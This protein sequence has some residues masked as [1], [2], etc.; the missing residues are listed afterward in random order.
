[1]TT[2][3][4]QK[5]RELAY[6]AETYRLS[7]NYENA[8]DYF[9]EA[10]KY[11]PNY[12]WA[13]AHRGETYRLIP[14]YDNAVRDFSKAIERAPSAWNFAHR[15]ATYRVMGTDYQTQAL[16]DLNQ[17]INLLPDYPWALA[18][19]AETYVVNRNYKA[20]LTD[21]RKVITLDENNIIFGG[22][23][24]IRG[25]Y[26]MVLLYDGQFAKALEWCEENLR[27]DPQDYVSAYVVAVTRSQL[28]SLEIACLD[29]DRARSLIQAKLNS[30][31][32]GDAI[33]RLS[34][35]LVL[36]GNYNQALKKLEESLL[37]K[38]DAHIVVCH[39]PVWHSLHANLA[40]QRIINGE[41]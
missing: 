20:S 6:Q 21:L 7:K 2:T 22:E 28:Y 30:V 40:F 14:N 3:Q 4:S 34:G 17:A 26:G 16:Q 39:D 27:R 11:N 31:L 10:I 19:R 15:G 13:Y 36:E 29:I 12:A 37:C 38:G 8:L 41:S 9:T 25:G 1:M 35:L 5:A 23:Y 24:P 32:H 33:Y 18:H